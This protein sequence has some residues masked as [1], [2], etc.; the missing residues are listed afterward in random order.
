MHGYWMEL[1]VLKD[2]WKEELKGVVRGKGEEDDGQI[3][4]DCYTAIWDD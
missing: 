2:V 3:V 1:L 4:N